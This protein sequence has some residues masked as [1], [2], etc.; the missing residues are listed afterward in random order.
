MP[1][2]TSTRAAPL[3]GG[4]RVAFLLWSMNSFFAGS[5]PRR[6]GHRGAAGTAPENTLPSFE[7]A[8]ELGAEGFELDVHGTADGEIVVFHDE[9]L[10]RT[11]DGRGPIRE[12]TLD[13]LAGLDAGYGFSTDG[14]RT[15]PFRD[16][17]I[18]IPTLRS[19]LE[20]FPDVPVIVEVKQADPPIEENLARL[21]QSM[22]AG[23]RVLVFSLDQKILDRYRALREEQAT[24]FGPDDVAEFLRR[25][26]SD[27]W[28][29][30]RPPGV[31]FAVPVRW[32][33]TQI[34]S[35]PFV[36]AAHRTGCEV[37]VWT[38]NEPRE[39]RDLLDLG[40]DGLISDYPERLSH[41]VAQRETME[42]P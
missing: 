13:D 18:R 24:G 3:D 23:P 31:A 38:I 39:M 26:G 35:G 41:A 27:D 29:G 42:R 40:V 2:P 9:T 30:Y 36:D 37:F 1:S 6:F 7:A 8:L 5:L 21:L 32:H 11:T 22:G 17:G 34:V 12:K 15:F 4:P 20:S 25:T 28:D 14:G 19:V 10:E 16:Q 33:G